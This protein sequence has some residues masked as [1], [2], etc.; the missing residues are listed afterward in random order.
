[1]DELISYIPL[2]AE[3]PEGFWPEDLISSGEDG[4]LLDKIAFEEGDLV[5]TEDEWGI[6][7]RLR[8][9]EELEFKL[10]LIKVISLVLGK[11]TV[12]AEIEGNDSSSYWSAA[13]TADLLKVR[14]ARA[15]LKPVISRNGQLVADPEPNKFVEI[16]LPLTLQF[17]NSGEVDLQWEGE[18]AQPINL[19]KCELI[20][21]TILEGDLNIVFEDGLLNAENSVIR[22]LE[23][24]GQSV[25]LNLKNFYI[26]KQ[27]F[28]IQWQEPDI[29]YW[30]GQIVP[31]LK[32]SGVLSPCTTTFR[33]L[34]D[35]TLSP[36][37]I[38]LDWEFKP[39]SR[40][41]ALPGVT[42]TT[43]EVVLFSLIF[44]DLD[45]AT[46]KRL[47]LAMTWGDGDLKV[48]SDFAW[49]RGN[50]RELQND[51]KNSNQPLFE[52]KL[53][54]KRKVSLVLAEFELGDLSKLPKFIH[55]LNTAIE[56]L[57]FTD[58]ENSLLK[59]TNLEKSDRHFKQDDWTGSFTLNLSQAFE[60]PFLKNRFSF[61]QLSNS[62]ANKKP[63]TI[64]FN[65][66]ELS[67]AVDMTI[68]ISDSLKFETFF[69]FKFNWE[70]FGINVDHNE[71][72][73][74]FSKIEQI[75]TRE[76]P[77][78][79]L[80]LNWRFK[81]KK[82]SDNKYHL[83]TLA[84][85]EFNYQI[86][87]APGAQIEIDFNRATK[88][89][90]PITFLISDFALTP[91]GL[92][93]EAIVTDR[94]A[95]LNGIDTQFRF[96]GSSFR[97]VENNIQGFTLM[98]SGPLPPALVGEATA[99]IALQFAQRN[100]NLD[101]VAGS[102]KLKGNQLLYSRST[103][104]Q[105]S[106]DAIGLKFVT[107][108]SN[109]HLYFTI[110][111]SAQYTPLPGDGGDFALTLLNAIKIDLIEC[112]LTGD[113]RVIAKYVKFLIELPRPTSFSFFGCF[114]M[115][116]RAIGFV[117]QADVFGGDAAMELTGQIKFVQ[118]AGDTPD[119][120]PDFH[121]LL[122]GVPTPGDLLPRIYL[123]ELPV[124]I[125]FGAAFK[126][127]GAVGFYDE[128]T[129]QGFD[130]EGTLEIQ[131]LPTF[132]ASFSFVRARVNESSPWLRAWFI[133][134]QVEKV[135]FQIPV[136]TLFIRE[137]GLGFGYRYT[138]TSIKAADRTNDVKALLKELQ[139]LSRT[140]GDLS[141]RDR[142]ALD[143]EAPGEDPRWTVVLRALISQTSA[144]PSPLQWNEAGERELACTFLFDA[145]IALR[146]DLTFF[147]AARAWL[148]TNYYDYYTNLDGKASVQGN[149]LF[150]GFVLLSPRQKR[151][152]A[153][154]AS[155]PNGFLGARPELPPLIQEAIRG[156]Q[157]SATLLIE[158]GLLHYEMGWPNMLRWK[159][160]LKALQ[161]DIRGGFIFRV[162]K[163]ELVIGSS[164]QASGTLDIKAEADL[165]IV[166]CRVSAFARVSY[167]ARFIAALKLKPP[168]SPVIYGAIG[169][170]VQIDFS[171]E[172]WICIDL[173]WFGSWEDS[174]SFSASIG[175]TAGL[176]LGIVGSN[177]GLRG[178]GT[179]SVSCFGHDI[180][181]TVNL[182]FNE[183]AINEARNRT[184]KYLQLGLEATD[185]EPVPGI[186]GVATFEL[187]NARSLASGHR[188]DGDFPDHK[189]I[190]TDTPELNNAGNVTEEQIEILPL[191]LEGEG[192][193]VPDYLIFTILDTKDGWS[194]FAILPQGKTEDGSQE[195]GFLPVPPD[196]TTTPS[197]DFKLDFPITGLTDLRHFDPNTQDWTDSLIPSSPSTSIS[198]HWNINWMAKI[199]KIKYI[200]KKESPDLSLKQYLSYAYRTNLPEKDGTNNTN[201]P[202]IPEPI[203]DPDPLTNSS[204]SYEDER[205]INP[206]DNTFEAAVRGAVN[207]FQSSPLFKRDQNLEYDQIL[208]NA[209]QPNTTIYDSSGQVPATKHEK[210]EFLSN[211]QAWQLRGQVIN[212]IVKDLREYAGVAPNSIERTNDQEWIK[213]SI[214][215][216]MGLVF[217]FKTQD[218]PQ[219]LKSSTGTTPNI[220]QRTNRRSTEPD[221]A[222][223][224]ARAFNTEQTSFTTKSPSFGDV[225]QFTDSST[226]AFAWNLIWKIDETEGKMLRSQ[227]DP[228]HHLAY[229]EVRR[230]TLDGGEAEVLYTRKSCQIL[231]YKPKH[232]LLEVTIS[233]LKK[234]QKNSDE[235]LNWS[236]E[237]LQKLEEIQRG[238]LDPKEAEDFITTLKKE[239]SIETALNTPVESGKL[240]LKT[241]I[242]RYSVKDDEKLLRRLQTRFQIVDRF[243]DS[244]SQQAGL[245]TEGRSYLYTITPV[246]FAGNP[247]RPLTLVA[248]RYPTQPPLVPVNGELIVNYQLRTQGN[249]GNDDDFDFKLAFTEKISPIT[250]PLIEPESIRVEWSDPISPN[251]QQTIPIDKYFLIFR[252]EDTLPIGS[253][254]LD[255]TTQ[256][257]RTKSLP[258]TNARQLATD[259]EIELNGTGS[260]KSKQATIL[261]QELKKAG[262]FP[263][264]KNWRPE[265]WRVFLQTESP[266]GVRSALAPVQLLLRFEPKV[267]PKV[268]LTLEDREERRP[269]E[270]EWLPKPI[271]F[272]LLP[273]EDLEAIVGIAHFPMPKKDKDLYFYGEKVDEILS[274]IS[275]Q[276]HPKG[277]RCVRFRWNQAP[278]DRPDYPLALNA[279]FSI[280][281]LNIDAYP[282]TTFND[283]KLLA[284]ALRP[285]QTIQLLI[286]D[287]LVRLPSDTLA[288]SQWEAWYPSTVLRR[289][290][291]E[292]IADDLSP[293]GSWYS[294]RESYLEWPEN[295]QPTG[296]IHPF[297]QKILDDLA[298]STK[299][300]V[301]I[302]PPIKPSSFEDFRSATPSKSD[303]Y[304][305]CILQRLGLST[306]FTL[307]EDGLNQ[308][309]GS[310]ITG[311]N[312]LKKLNQA[313]D[314]AKEDP[315]WKSLSE[316]LFIELL[317]QPSKSLQLTEGTTSAESL[318]ALIQ[319]SLRPVAKPYLQYGQ[320]TLSGPSGATLDLVLTLEADHSC[321]LINQA[322]PASGQIE[323]PATSSA[324]TIR[325]S[326][327][328]PLNGQTTILL[329]SPKLPNLELA[330][331]WD[332]SALPTPLP[333][334]QWF[335]YDELRKRLTVKAPFF[336]LTEDERN[337]KLQALR[338]T[339]S[340]AD[341][342]KPQFRADEIT[343]FNLFSVTW[344]WGWELDAALSGTLPSFFRYEEREVESKI[345]RRLFV[346][347]EFF[348]ASTT[349]REG[350]WR[351]LPLVLS[352][353]DRIKESFKEEAIAQFNFAPLQTFTARHNQASYFTAPLEDLEA[354]ISQQSKELLELLKSNNDISNLQDIHFLGREWLKFKNIL[355]AISSPDQSVPQLTVPTD[356]K[357]VADVLPDFLLWTQRFFDASG[358]VLSTKAE[359]PWLATAY[360]RAT[361][362][363]YSS[364]DSNGRLTYDHLIEDKWAHNYRYYIQPSGRYDLLWQSLRNSPVFASTLSETKL[365]VVSPNPKQAALDVVLDRTY[366]V[367]APLVLR[368][369]RLDLPS[370]PQNPAQPGNIWEVI[371]AQHPEQALI[372][373]NQTLARQLSYR[374]IAFA[375]FRRFANPKQIT[376]LEKA[377]GNT[378]S[379]KVAW[380]ENYNPALPTTYPDLPDHLKLPYEEQKLLPIPNSD[381]YNNEQAIWNLNLPARLGSFQQGAT[382]LH[383][384]ALPYYY[385]HCLLVIALTT[386]KVSK[387]TEVTQK[388][389][390]YISPKPIAIV[391]GIEKSVSE[392]H[393]QLEIP[394]MRL[395]DCLPTAAQKQWRAEEPLGKSDPKPERKLSSLPDL[396]VIYQIQ[397]EN[398][399]NIEVQAQ[400]LFN[401]DEQN[402]G[403]NPRYELRQLGKAFELKFMG[404]S[405]LQAPPV[406]Q[407][408]A[409][410]ILG[411]E[412]Y[413][414]SRPSLQ[415]RYT[416]DKVSVPTKNKLRYE[417]DILVIS[418]IFTNEDRD[419]LL[420]SLVDTDQEKADLR[421][422]IE[423]LVNNDFASS[424]PIN[425]IF[426]DEALRQQVIHDCKSLSSLSQNFMTSDWFHEEPISQSL[427]VESLPPEHENLK[428]AVSFPE[429]SSCTIVWSGKMTEEQKAELLK[430]KA[431][432]EFT[433]QLKKLSEVEKNDI[434]ILNILPGLDQL[435]SRLTNPFGL[436]GEVQLIITKTA[437]E[438]KYSGLSWKGL[439]FDEYIQG[440][441]E[442]TKI[443]EFSTAIDQVITKLEQ[444]SREE[445]VSAPRPLP[446][447][448]N[449]VL[450]GRLVIDNDQLSW[451]APAPNDLQRSALR[452]IPADADFSLSLNNLLALIDQ[453]QSVNLEPPTNPAAPPRPQ[454]QEL[455]QDL[456]T[457]LTIGSTQLSW[458]GQSPNDNQRELLKTLQIDRVGLGDTEFG[459]AL[460]NLLAAIDINRTVPLAL[461]PQ[462]PRQK[463]VPDVL[464]S[465]LV[466]EPTLIRW[467]GRIRNN[468]QEKAIK[469]L[470]EQGDQ[471][472]KDA[473]NL[474]HNYLLN[475]RQEQSFDVPT[476]PSTKN[477]PESLK[478]QLLI[479]NALIRYHGLMT[480]AEGKA[481]Q[482]L[483]ELVPDK[484][485][486]QRLH[487]ASLQSG[488]NGAK[489][490]ISAQRG[491]A[492]RKE[493]D[494]RPQSLSSENSGVLS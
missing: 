235:T 157:F 26:D 178:S 389:F 488:L 343:R 277:I 50:E 329:R 403:Q 167:G 31:N 445:T 490:K 79:D 68:G 331:E 357:E 133:F 56:A 446:S 401:F 259:V 487:N 301:Q 421:N 337:N 3:L 61:V 76:E 341:Q 245:P 406:T 303:P 129:K 58:I 459:N 154:V 236:D 188:V 172:F 269:A 70:K 443:D 201:E 156:G 427:N 222:I 44:D 379:F 354:K 20:P 326:I 434:T 174:A 405:P 432:E 72:V 113:A 304:G 36:K 66:V 87:Q 197:N 207:Q 372:E 415:V 261:L 151:L 100:G 177:T 4:E 347:K 382:V 251:G 477:L 216:Q 489:I 146:S 336:S 85:R 135:S 105:F 84:T 122:I 454:P 437:D 63:R 130:G 21:G 214:L 315:S 170:D 491:S 112:P 361:G 324:Q 485:A 140:Q 127:N 152:L 417:N 300:D 176:E 115:E 364:P 395:W 242:L 290:S 239:S 59:P 148:N 431:D 169:I 12:I 131:G 470:L 388:D 384:E 34:F 387:I 107:S 144:S 255:S 351:S 77:K 19:P 391:S 306:A 137:V 472:F 97:I 263:Q 206:S 221:S 240:D 86:Q 467:Q 205:V 478:N 11:G 29:N 328:L 428:K 344:G 368:S 184:Q 218:I 83:F 376:S 305:W 483:T 411:L 484:Q 190:S 212:N 475:Q 155:N 473:L 416:L 380:V 410:F 291:E 208:N 327:T 183:G 165:G 457:Q 252:K 393:R 231:D 385:E 15:L 469:T 458:A 5:G 196:D 203:R 125:N 284:Q 25:A 119:A 360:P 173:G 375:L 198:Y 54:P 247:G 191:A 338:D 260:S 465:Q 408:Q 229:Y 139:A 281:E 9:I 302:R 101:L 345:E 78:K 71:G 22:R 396:D 451:I 479:G 339:F 39:S 55:Q 363:A 199:R 262:V 356:L 264:S 73:Q 16:K 398:Q 438:K 316:H 374:Q 476:R 296:G 386:H 111:G 210:L 369:S 226:I 209:F 307:Y 185:V 124:N 45:E 332:L 166:G 319:V 160:D 265:A 350:Q 285:L 2:S 232:K 268:R 392:R 64:D 449:T 256:R 182:G 220:T 297:L 294:W 453:D 53:T 48:T 230:R 249:N 309:A 126:L 444:V 175:F 7:A 95:R 74:L 32:D 468:V 43:P 153:H 49:E 114:D 227:S 258:T 145:V 238:N 474:V 272:P 8:A 211:Q 402:D 253:Y 233:T 466:I 57:N 192:F 289:R 244:L 461:L 162:T 334:P 439:L 99:D 254:G 313:L 353:T 362:P 180:S 204:R 250:P 276:S 38:R 464:K 404:D 102:A 422:A 81:G 67:F 243:N 349:D 215:F 430:I 266:N 228:E 47:S 323:I 90:E 13:I 413:Q 494:L 35:D 288:T 442:W 37:E 195:L 6:L 346:K 98:G 110:S 217:R 14:F 91:K 273:P 181:L 441:K 158:P 62:E 318:L 298:K 282:Q 28:A 292:E 109:F 24:S 18:E 325:Q 493:S 471:A 118:G 150:S 492:N 480:L 23:S 312:A 394:L 65:N 414:I 171:V 257:S 322:D 383:W 486:I 283:P 123:K 164:Y 287:D 462:R 163:E 223:K 136:V 412:L 358:D 423:Q 189:A 267:E 121:S 116:L 435:P 224:M 159:G 248:T 42:I 143:L 138:L 447:E 104:F 40:I 460:D 330:W 128:P 279:A 80:G 311:E 10:P 407:P 75:G 120:R 274:K 187:E 117:P 1:M 106:L 377:L 455:D 481:L 397:T 448:L 299:V 371:I 308:N 41:L 424:D 186:S 450:Q 193:N 17:N 355:E 194:Y 400:I 234:L 314:L 237:V 352:E 88:A 456:R 27:C 213:K 390:E 179:I 278:S 225:K 149:P 30:L 436:Q 103:R 335:L 280:W 342:N 420:L 293:F 141:K 365:S 463:D 419:N 340:E 317:F 381:E 433:K 51:P 246:D 147:M 96:N 82:I 46:F 321:S 310:L 425:P 482:S 271:Q 132:S 142:W 348:A 373:R 359:K 168:Y 295:S 452:S 286:G 69:D 440:I 370:Q 108:D 89:D 409:D 202:P 378:Y 200:N 366:P 270:L 333:D 241:A 60:F 367:A 275:Y 418:T 426:T 219:W 134:L 161:V 94:P 320:I 429:V 399:G 93:V 52:A 33:T 92:N